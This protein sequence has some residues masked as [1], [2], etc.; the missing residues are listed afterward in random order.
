M[1]ER[2]FILAEFDQHRSQ[3]NVLY[4][5]EFH[6]LLPQ[7]STKA[8]QFLSA[9]RMIDEKIYPPNGSVIS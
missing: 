3:L 4:L 6:G 5:R 1:S 9:K 2:Y 7:L 8:V